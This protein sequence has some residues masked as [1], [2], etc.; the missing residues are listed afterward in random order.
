MAPMSRTPPKTGA[1]RGPGRPRLTPDEW[2][3][4]LED[5]CRRYDVTLGEN[6]LPPFPSGRRESPQHREWMALYK[7]HRRLTDGGA[8]GSASQPRRQELLSDQK[9]CCTVCRQAL[10]LAEARLDDLTSDPA[11]LHPRCLA[12]VQLA[13]ELG[14]DALERARARLL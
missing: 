2:R 6:A 8:A 9:G 3:V 4:R 1:P 10:D 11:V 12:F 5:Y 13:R 14:P 7:A